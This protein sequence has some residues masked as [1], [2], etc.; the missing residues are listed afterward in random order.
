MILKLLK[1]FFTKFLN[2]NKL[3]KNKSFFATLFAAILLG[4]VKIFAW[5]TIASKK[6]ISIF[7]IK[8]WFKN[9]TI[10]RRALFTLLILV[11]FRIAATITMPGVKLNSGNVNT[12]SVSSFLG[13]LNLLGGGGIAKFSIV[14]LGI[15]PYITASIIIQLLST[16]AFPA[17]ARLAKGGTA[18]RRKLNIITRWITIFLAVPQA[19]ALSA[20]LVNDSTGNFTFTTVLGSGL[21]AKYAFVTLIMIAGS[22]FALFL[23]EQIT[24]KGVG[25]GTSLIIFSGIAVN[26]PSHFETA[27]NYFIGSHTVKSNY[28]GIMNF[29]GYLLLFFVLLAFIA[30]TYLAERRIPIQQTG[31]GLNLNEKKLAY[32]PMKFNPAGVIPVIFASS[33]LLIPLTVAQLLP[34]YYSSREWILNNLTFT[35]PVG[36]SIYLVL[37]IVFTVFFS[38]VQYN[39]DRI[40]ENFQKNGTFIPGIKPGDQTIKYITGVLI[41]ISSIAAVYLAFVASLNYLEQIGGWPYQATFGGTSTIILVTVTIE[42]L[43]QF[44]GRKT[45]ANLTGI[46]RETSSSSDVKDLLW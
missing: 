18:G 14:A 21:V 46:K 13:L 27:Y 45:S 39:P 24:D 5:I 6:V 36:L 41:R 37:I 25:N 34:T 31:S 20:T 9:K 33:I 26:L 30:F 11:I 4:F 22:L 3:F 8:K 2:I 10:L 38:Y 7:N 16:D 35:A 43:R 29:V 42:T 1:K 23:G 19:I 28:Y 15:S 12:G 17:V 44:R 40:G 32:L